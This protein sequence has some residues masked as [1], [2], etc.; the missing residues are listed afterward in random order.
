MSVT[1]PLLKATN[2]KISYGDKL[3]LDK[4]DLEIFPKEVVTIIGP[5]G[6][7]KTTLLRL[8]LGLLKTDSGEIT[9][10]PKLKIGYVPQK[11]SVDPT[12]PLTVR[13]FLALGGTL[14]K[15]R[16]Q[17]ILS[18]VGISGLADNPIQSVS[19]G[20]MQRILL[21]RALLRDPDL[22]VLD[23][24][25]QGVDVTG[26]AELY[27]LITKIRNSRG[28]GV[29]LVSHDLH[30]VMSATDRVICLNGHVCCAG[31]PETVSADPEYVAL[32]GRKVAETLAVYHH[33]HDHHHTAH[34]EV[35][36]DCGEAHKHG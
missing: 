29:L 14:E 13:R 32:F 7:G 36:Q 9:Q 1:A 31:H 5:N 23:E 22:L 12:L 19:G 16:V 26:Q 21:A 17:A 25:A 2:L 8:V 24:P 18:E 33:R 28:C 10:K 11:I 30:M 34:G 6:A 15:G 4:V 27:D 20:E 35:V 3:I